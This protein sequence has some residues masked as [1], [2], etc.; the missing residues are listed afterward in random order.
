MFTVF[1]C[2]FAFFRFVFA[3]FSLFFR[4]FFA[5]FSLFSTSFLHFQRSRSSGHLRKKKK[6]NNAKTKAEKK[7][8]TKQK[9]CKN[10]AKKSEKKVKTNSLFFFAFGFVFL[11]YFFLIEVWIG[12]CFFFAFFFFLLFSNWGLDWVLFFFGLV[13]AFFICLKFFRSRLKAF[14]KIITRWGCPV[15]SYNWKTS[16]CWYLILSHAHVD[17]IHPPGYS[18]SLA[19]A[20]PGWDVKRFEGF[21]GDGSKPLRL[22]RIQILND[23]GNFGNFQ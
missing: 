8:K 3:F 18:A 21:V 7:A 4:F 19:R 5:F 1:R 6:K 22:R 9:K 17:L 10:E 12:V 20:N 15:I 2:F 16:P 13:F 11:F 14:H 23:F